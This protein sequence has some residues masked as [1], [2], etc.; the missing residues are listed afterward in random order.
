MPNGCPVRFL[1]VGFGYWG[2][3]IARTIEN[4]EKS[5]LVAICDL[6]PERCVDA[7]S[8]HGSASI[9]QDLNSVD[10][11][12]FDAVAIATPT[13]S[14]YEIAK[15][16]LG[17][18]KHVLVEKPLTAKLSE[19]M[20]LVEIA[21]QNKLILMVD[22]TFVYSEPIQFI[23]DRLDQGLLGEL[24][25]LDSNRVNLGIFQPDVSVMWDL[26]V[27]D[28]AILQFLV[29]EKPIAVSSTGFTHKASRHHAIATLSLSYETNFF[30]HICVSWLSPVKVR[31]FVV[32]GSLETIVFNDLSNDEKIKI[33]DSGVDIANSSEAQSALLS[34]RLGDVSVPRLRIIEPLRR[35]I[36]HF[37]DCIWLCAQPVTSGRR[38]LEI[39]S[40][41][42]AAQRSIQDG[43]TPI[44]VRSV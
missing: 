3:N 42:E 19:A 15:L 22:H 43:G 39:I 7:S 31:N 28:L 38:A 9:F 18:G 37:V 34:Y 40:I 30:A 26:A 5:E 10:P 25:Y 13:S 12:T 8:R 32:G 1:L 41:L 35:E 17:L 21:E 23:K 16:F 4:S 11:N 6:S 24:N 14:H 27:H 2:P 29:Q 44:P 33:Y 20:E 36:E